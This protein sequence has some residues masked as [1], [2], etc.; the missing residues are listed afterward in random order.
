MVN[1]NYLQ[2]FPQGNIR[3]LKQQSVSYSIIFQDYAPKA[4]QFANVF[5]EIRKQAMIIYLKTAKFP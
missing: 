5:R 3:I 1:K 2:S 4:K